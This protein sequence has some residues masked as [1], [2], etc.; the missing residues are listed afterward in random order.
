TRRATLLRVLCFFAVAQPK[1]Y[2]KCKKICTNFSKRIPQALLKSYEKT[3]P[4]CPKAAVIFVTQKSKEFCADPEESWVQEAVRWLDQTSAPQ[5]PP[6]SSTVS[7]AAVPEDI[8]DLE[9]LI[10]GTASVPRQAGVL[11][12]PIPGAGT[13]VSQAV[14]GSGVRTEEPNTSTLTVQEAMRSSATPCSAL[15]GTGPPS[16]IYTEPTANGS[17]GSMRSVDSANKSTD[18]AM[19][20]ATEIPP[21]PSNDLRVP[22]APSAFT[23][24]ATA[25]VNGTEIAELSP[26]F[27]TTTAPLESVPSKPAIGLESLGQASENSTRKPTTVLKG[28]A[29]ATRGSTA[30]PTPPGGDTG[31]VSHRSGDERDTVHESMAGA[32]PANYL[33]TVG[34]EGPPYS[35]P[36]SISPPGTLVFS[37]TGFLHQ[38][39]AQG[40]SASPD[41]LV[42]STPSFLSASRTHT[43][44]LVL[45]GSV[46][47]I[48]SAALWMYLKSR[49]FPGE[50]TKEMVQLLR[51]H[52]Q[53]S[54]I[55]DY[56]M[57]D[58]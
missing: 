35:S 23:A 57:E 49:V 43:L 24:D 16:T 28:T 51:I 13:T 36:E 41:V 56:A 27:L 29:D 31:S 30:Q 55:N 47:C 52:Q 48:C 26:A 33:S 58:V 9:R 14:H 40:A 7:S 15:N 17:K 32:S 25:V 46:L 21:L 37:F 42:E 4:S 10:G 22:H 38:N 53:G 12:S 20:P 54:R 19:S 45:L 5:D 39:R 11:T 8:G 44:S 50:P 1:A 2:V 34:R 3:E 18:S 6:P